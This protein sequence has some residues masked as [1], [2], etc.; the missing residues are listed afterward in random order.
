LAVLTISGR[1]LKPLVML[2]YL[3]VAVNKQAVFIKMPGDPGWFTNP[4][5]E[6]DGCQTL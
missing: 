6:D 2:P 3:H 5:S 4:G 1:V